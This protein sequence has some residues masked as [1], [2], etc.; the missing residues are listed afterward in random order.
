MANQ[1][2]ERMACPA[3]CLRVWALLEG[4]P[5][6]TLAFGQMTTARTIPSL[7]GYE[8]VRDLIPEGVFLHCTDVWRLSL[9]FYR[10]EVEGLRRRMVLELMR[11]VHDSRADRVAVIMEG[12]SQISFPDAWQILGLDFEDIRDRGMEGLRWRAYDY[13]MSGFEVY[14][15]SVRFERRT[16]TEPCAPPNGG[17]ATRLGSLGVTEGPPSVS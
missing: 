5:S 10:D 2:V 4:Q 14:C 1:T 3:R 11:D 12:P 6:L 9:E 8:A 13:E 17:P 15:S 16:I 7:P